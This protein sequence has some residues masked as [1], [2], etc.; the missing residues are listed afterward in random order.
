MASFSSSESE[1]TAAEANA[2]MMAQGS[3]TIEAMAA[4]S[5]A[6]FSGIATNFAGVIQELNS[7]GTD[8]EVTSMLQNLALVSSGTAMDLTGA[9]I[10]ASATNLNATVKTMFEGA[11]INL[12]AGGKEFEAYVEDIAASTSMSV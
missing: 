8:V 6:D 4:I 7:M 5:T 10:S 9:K 3:E 12:K 11:T 1:A 2:S